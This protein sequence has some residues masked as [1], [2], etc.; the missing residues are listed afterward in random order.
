MSH[1][2]K[3]GTFILQHCKVKEDP[4]KLHGVNAIE[5]NDSENQKS[6]QE[7]SDGECQVENCHQCQAGSD[8]ESS[9]SGCEEDLT[10]RISEDLNIERTY[11]PKT[12]ALVGCDI[13][14]KN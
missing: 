6:D 12:G 10:L 13:T 2:W 8:S 4:K 5:E 1:L 7:E 11:N 14:S 3:D 9:L